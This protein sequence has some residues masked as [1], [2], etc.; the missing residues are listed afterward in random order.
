[1]TRSVLL[2]NLP[3]ITKGINKGRLDRPK[4]AELY[5]FTI[6]QIY[7]AYNN[8]IQIFRVKGSTLSFEEYL[9]KLKEANIIPEQLGNDNY[10]WHLSRYD[11]ESPYTKETCRFVYKHINMSEQVLNGR[12]RFVSP[13]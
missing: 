12:N 9:N 11:D 2:G 8:W 4:T 5:G 6:K 13:I 3:K 7:K 10:D 1:M